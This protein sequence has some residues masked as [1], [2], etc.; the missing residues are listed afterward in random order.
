MS[1]KPFTDPLVGFFLVRM[2]G[3]HPNFG[4]PYTPMV[5]QMID[6]RLY[7]A[8]NELEPVEFGGFVGDDYVKMPLK[9]LEWH[10][11]PD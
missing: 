10:S 5:V 11:L 9:A 8:D 3:I 4:K 2:K 6:N 7:T 1:W